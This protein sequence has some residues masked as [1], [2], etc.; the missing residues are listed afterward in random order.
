MTVVCGVACALY[1]TVAARDEI[2]VRCPIL[3]FKLPDKILRV[4]A[5]IA[6]RGRLEPK[7]EAHCKRDEHRLG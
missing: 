7:Q 6:G 4:S 2:G 1:L 3:R 5:G